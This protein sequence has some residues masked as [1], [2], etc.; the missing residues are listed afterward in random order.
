[1]FFSYYLRESKGRDVEMILSKEGLTLKR[2]TDGA[3]FVLAVSPFRFGAYLLAC[4]VDQV[5]RDTYLLEKEA[6][7]EKNGRS[8][9]KAGL[10][11][12]RPTGRQN[13]N[14]PIKT[15]PS[16]ILCQEMPQP[17][18]SEDLVKFKIPLFAVDVMEII[19][20]ITEHVPAPSRY[21]LADIVVYN[22]GQKLLLNVGGSEFAELIEKDR[23]LLV[24]QLKRWLSGQFAILDTQ[25]D[26]EQSE[27]EERRRR[28]FFRP[29]FNRNGIFFNGSQ[30]PRLRV[31]GITSRLSY[32]DVAELYLVMSVCRGREISQQDHENE[33]GV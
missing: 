7:L 13:N 21:F 32:I 18:K 1:M 23:R 4:L 16:V 31:H 15:A 22:E 20:R 8:F 33:N 24:Y 6:R 11:V 2:T 27:G 25:P 29:S 17:G 3:A 14:F 12:I 19:A 26:S 9:E 28:R 5:G 10:V 30:Q